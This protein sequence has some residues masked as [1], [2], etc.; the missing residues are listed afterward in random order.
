MIHV[1]RSHLLSSI[2]LSVVHCVGHGINLYHISTQASSDLNCI[3]REYFRAY[4]FLIL[5]IYNAKIDIEIYFSIFPRKG[6]MN[7]NVFS[8][9]AFRFTQYGCPSFVPVLG[10]RNDNRPNGHYS[11]PDRHSYVRVCDP[12]RQEKP[13]QCLLGHTQLLHFTVHLY[14]D[15]WNWKISPT[16]TVPELFLRPIIYIYCG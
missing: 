1:W 9:F 14:G 13:I 11:D 4:V 16:T 3:F 8:K 2:F 12:I 15:A 5:I 6:D 7:S 10:V